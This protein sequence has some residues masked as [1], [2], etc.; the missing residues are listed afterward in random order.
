MVG[1]VIVGLDGQTLTSEEG[2]ALTSSELF[3]VILFARNYN[4]R[5]Q[6][7]KLVSSIKFINP[8]LLIFVDQEGAI[9]RFEK[10]FTRIQNAKFFGDL[11]DEK[12]PEVALKAVK[13]AAFLMASELKAVNVDVTIAP[14]VDVHDPKSSIIGQ[15]ERA[16]HANPDVIIAL[17][18]AFM[19]GLKQAGCPPIIKHFPGHGSA[20][21]DTHTQQV[22]DRRPR[23]VIEA[24]D[25]KPF[26]V[27]LESGEATAVMVGHVVYPAIDNQL[28]VF[29]KVWNSILRQASPTAC[30]FTDCLGMV[31]VGD[32][33]DR[34]K[35]QHA[36][37]A[38]CDVVVYSNQL[39]RDADG[40]AGI[41]PKP[42]SEVVDAVKGLPDSISSQNRRL[43][44]GSQF[45]S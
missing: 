3:G 35:C 32:W 10:G 27:L 2:I 16:F 21:G 6:L 26:Q 37:E 40:K 17:A 23:D 9:W 5:E 30:V 4:N 24:L 36:F 20:T 28:A 1:R 43:A 31:G 34:D 11:F 33:S 38:G 41:T 22:V 15:R 8:E 13:E 39:Y 7:K 44:F 14:V 42:I 25:L 12:G 19:D 18:K 29:S 45:S